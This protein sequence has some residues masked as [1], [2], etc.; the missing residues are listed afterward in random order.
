M[1][2]SDNNPSGFLLTQFRVLDNSKVDSS[3]HPVMVDNVKL[4]N[5][6]LWKMRDKEN[7]HGA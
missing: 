5:A 3:T 4:Y 2:R 1:V 6:V 7:V